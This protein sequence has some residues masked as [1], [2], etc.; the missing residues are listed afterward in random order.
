MINEAFSY[1]STHVATNTIQQE[2]AQEKYIFIEKH[3]GEK[4]SYTQMPFLLYVTSSTTS[5]SLSHVVFKSFF[6]KC[7]YTMMI[8]MMM[9]QLCDFCHFSQYI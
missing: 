9:I 4:E 3:R 1:I 5:L 2:R 7:I 8:M 6:T